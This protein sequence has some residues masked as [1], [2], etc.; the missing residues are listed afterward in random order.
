[1]E[2]LSSC[3]NSSSGINDED[4]EGNQTTEV[5]QESILCDQTGK[6]VLLYEGFI[7]SEVEVEMEDQQLPED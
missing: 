2:D 7:L 6:E 5:Y 4:D 1:M 3:I